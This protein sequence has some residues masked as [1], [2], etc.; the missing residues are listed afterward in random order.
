MRSRWTG[1]AVVGFGLCWVACSELA[2][3]GFE[4][5]QVP[6]LNAAT[7]G[8]GTIVVDGAAVDYTVDATQTQLLILVKRKSA[9]GG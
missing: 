8:A 1:R 3:P 4:E 2:L 9:A 5:E 6:P 7:G